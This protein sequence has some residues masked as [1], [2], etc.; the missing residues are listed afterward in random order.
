[1]VTRPSTWS[2]LAG[3]LIALLVAAGPAASGEI[4]AQRVGTSS[5]TFLKIG[6]G[7]RPVSMGRAASPILGDPTSLFH[8]PAGLAYVERPTFVVER[9]SWLAD[10]DMTAAGI[11]AA[12][13]WGGVAGL[14]AL[15]LSSDMKETTELEPDGTGR[16][17]S[18]RDLA[19]GLTYG[20]HLTDRFSFGVTG[21]YIYEALGT[22]IGGPSTSTWVVDMGTTF[23]TGFRG[24]VLAMSIT[25]FGP[26]FQPGGSYVDPRPGQGSEL[27]FAG[28]SPPTT[29]ALASSYQAFTLP[30][31]ALYVTGEFV[32]PADND[33]T[34][35][36]G[37]ELELYDVLE[38]RGGYDGA[39]DAL[40]WSGG[41]GVRFGGQRL[42]THIDYA[43]SIS[44]HFN[45]VDRVTLRFEF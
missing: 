44:E 31:A 11:A 35:R 20:R 19:F 4:G 13:P 6:V 27:E 12:I 38:F 32:R 45:R 28:F 33:E 26:D 8:N 37:G 16:S 24:V 1:M 9:V 21:R 18:H 2:A 3:G 43:F 34:L 17:F 5:G 14:S 30:E 15:S 42:A 41:L 29:F 23:D 22:E 10:V 25:S 39:S 7:A 36:F 40:P